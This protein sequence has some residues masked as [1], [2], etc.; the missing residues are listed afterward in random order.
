[1]DTLR[2]PFESGTSADDTPDWDVGE[3]AREEEKVREL[4]PEA[5]GQD[6]RRMQVRA[7]N[8]W[9]SLLGDASFPSIELLEPENLED[10]GPN[11]VLLD[12]SCGIEDPAVQFL[13]NKLA[14]EC[15][16][17][18]AAITKLSDVPPRSLL[19][20]ITDH[21]MQI[22]AN[23]APIGFEAEFVNE[24][25]AS[26]L[27]RGILLPF[28]SDE[29]T[30]DFIYG[31][32]NWKEM[33]DAATADELL[34]AIDQAID[35]KLAA[36]PSEEEDTPQK[37][38]AGPVTEWADSPAHETSQ[39]E[40]A[41]A[42]A[43]LWDEDEAAEERGS[44]NAVN[45]DNVASFGEGLV[46]LNED[47]DDLPTP[48]FGHFELDDPELDE[49]GEEIDEDEEDESGASY[50]FASLADYIEAPSK[51]AVDLEAERFDPEDYKVEEPANEVEEPQIEEPSNEDTS[52]GVEAVE[53]TDDDVELWDKNDGEEGGEEGGEEVGADE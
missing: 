46:N 27:Y 9:A 22:L 5:I 24:R 36:G 8:H 14:D 12:F 2:G 17:H 16:T 20:R 42:E 51:K 31:V 3:S 43:S 13:G 10:F 1:M 49:F 28:S 47:I 34:L 33:A 39:D 38:H 40:P 52:Q 44:D 21:Y 11:S 29:E 30:I 45:N 53:G 41:T 19:S 15:G 48:D 23:Q 32:I 26:V 18:G 25:G 50:S 7:Y 6:E 35:E 4:P 37:H